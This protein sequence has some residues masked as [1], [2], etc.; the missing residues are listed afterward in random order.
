MNMCFSICTVLS[1]VCNYRHQ[2]IQNDRFSQYIPSKLQQSAET[3]AYTLPEF[4]VTVALLVV[5]FLTSAK[6]KNNKKNN[7]F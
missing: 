3:I 5:M 6:K 7:E 1:T 2:H 4:G